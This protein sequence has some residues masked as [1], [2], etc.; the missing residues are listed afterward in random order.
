M[1]HRRHLSGQTL[2][3][4]KIIPMSGE[5]KSVYIYHFNVSKATEKEGHF[6]KWIIFFGI[7]GSHNTDFPGAQ[8]VENAVL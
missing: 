1:T 2:V 6:A 3:V 5:A 8:A 4:S 7:K